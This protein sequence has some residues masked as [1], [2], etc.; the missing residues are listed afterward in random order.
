[1]IPAPGTTINARINEVFARLQGWHLV[2]RSD[3]KGPSPDSSHAYLPKRYLFDTGLL[4]HFRELGMPSI[5][6][7]NTRAATARGPLGGGLENQ[8]AVELARGGATLCGRKKT[9]SGGEID[10]LVHPGFS[11]AERSTATAQSD[12]ICGL[13]G[14][15][16]AGATRPLCVRG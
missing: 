2:L 6:V 16:G 15:C 11:W 3:Q 9:P 8:V 7:L 12:H 1:V 13:D 10:F 14:F 4:R 5:D